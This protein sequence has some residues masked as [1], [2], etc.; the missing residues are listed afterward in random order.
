MDSSDVNFATCIHRGRGLSSVCLY[1]TSFSFL[2]QRAEIWHT[3]YTSKC[4]KSLQWGIF[5]FLRGGFQDPW[6]CTQENGAV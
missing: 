3:D 2:L 1:V 5:K 6:S 4:K